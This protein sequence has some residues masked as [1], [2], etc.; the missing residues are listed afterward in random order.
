MH[1]TKWLRIGAQDSRNEMYHIVHLYRKEFFGQQYCSV[2]IILSRFGWGGMLGT[3]KS[4]FGIDLLTP[5]SHNSGLQ[6]IY[7]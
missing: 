7:R 6:G 4:V 2:Y 5:Y 1:I 3:R